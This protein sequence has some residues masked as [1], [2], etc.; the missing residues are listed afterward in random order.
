M[1]VMNGLQRAADAMRPAK[2]L[3]G[4][5]SQKLRTLSTEDGS[6]WKRNPEV[7]FR[8]EDGISL[9]ALSAF[10]ETNRAAL[11][12]KTSREVCEQIVKPAT[13]RPGVPLF[14]GLSYVGMLRE[15]T[16]AGQAAWQGGPVTVG[17]RCRLTAYV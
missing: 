10:V 7:A 3:G 17:R 14:G 1:H 12:G 15:R 13:A 8:A 9:A 4:M 6:D 2:A 11:E 5:F 16:K